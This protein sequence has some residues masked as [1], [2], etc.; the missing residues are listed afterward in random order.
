ME[1]SQKG[2]IPVMLTPFLSDGNIDYTALTELTEIYL[3]AGAAG[4]FANCLS[5]EMFELTDVE[6]IQAIKHIIKVV[7][8]EVP[9]IATGT[10]GGPI[11]AQADF[12]K[13]VN[14]TGVNAV[15]AITSLLAKRKRTR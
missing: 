8:N 1:N 15:I 7:N 12:V 9:V 2:F 14:D 4:L 6:R 13:R 10:F 3:Q 11:A 5:S